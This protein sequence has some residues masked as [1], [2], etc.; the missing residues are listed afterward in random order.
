MHCYYLIITLDWWTSQSLTYVAI[1]K[2]Y[3]LFSIVYGVFHLLQPPPWSL[4]HVNFGPQ[5]MVERGQEVMTDIQGELLN[6]LY[7]NGCAE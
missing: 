7:L 2:R 3:I 4:L 6:A 1:D 5:H